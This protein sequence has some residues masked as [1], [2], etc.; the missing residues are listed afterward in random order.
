MASTT[1]GT[2]TFNLDVDQLIEDA[3]GK[4][5]DEYVSGVDMDKARRTLNLIL[6]EMQNINIPLNK[7]ETTSFDTVISDNNYTLDANI[8]DVLELNVQDNSI[9]GGL[10]LPIERKGLR[11]FHQIP[12]KVQE[13]RPTLWTTDRQEDA[14]KV[15]LW[16][17][18]DAVYTITMLVSK[19]IED[20]TASYQKLDISYRYLPLLTKWLAYE[21]SINLEG[22]P[23]EKI[24][25]LREEKA[26]AAPSTFEEDRERVDM[27]IR[28]RIRRGR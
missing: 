13:N 21:L 4:I 11:E 8:V 22:V 19:R 5:G 9:Q 3:L 1:S 23:P 15:K 24:L 6:I 14:V 26:Q 18:P 25:L 20:I 7:I 27:V 12:N 17:T 10:E 16:P 2:T 28:P